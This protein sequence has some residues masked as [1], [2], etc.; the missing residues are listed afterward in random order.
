MQLHTSKVKVNK[1]RK[2]IKLLIICSEIA[3]TQ[4]PD[5]VGT[6]QLNCD[7]FKELVSAKRVTIE[8]E[9]SEQT[10]LIKINQNDI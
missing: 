5:H 10:P 2:D 3:H 8:Q 6:S 4:I 7:N 9:I 1:K